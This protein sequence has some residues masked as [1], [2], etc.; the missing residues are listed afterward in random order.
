MNW[1]PDAS[2]SS[3]QAARDQRDSDRDPALADAFRWVLAAGWLTSPQIMEAMDAGDKAS[4]RRLERMAQ[5]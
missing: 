3:I 1:V 4:K 5:S 2:T